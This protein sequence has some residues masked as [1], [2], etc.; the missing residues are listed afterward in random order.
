[1]DNKLL[2][3]LGSDA[4]WVLNKKLVKHLGCDATLLLQHFIDLQFKL[5]GGDEF[6]QQQ[7]RITEETSLGE[8]T[9]RECV[10]KLNRFGL[11][12]I[13]KKGLPAKNWYYIH[14]KQVV[15]MLN[16]QWSE[17]L[18]T[19]GQENGPQ[20]KELIKKELSEKELTIIPKE[21]NIVL[22]IPKEGKF[23]NWKQ[24]DN[25]VVANKLIFTKH[26]SAISFFNNSTFQHASLEQQLQ[27][28]KNNTEK[29]N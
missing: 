21:E 8:H 4:Y 15:R 27:M 5:F 13:T 6:Y 1:M 26:P 9:I 7:E 19:S 18:T 14:E 12:S 23:C 25:Y 22:N 10:K 2:N 28:I 17:N 11:L 3:I 29:Y 20:R 16:N 24:L